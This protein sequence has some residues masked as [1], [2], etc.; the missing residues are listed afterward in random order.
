[1]KTGRRSHSRLEDHRRNKKRLQPPWLA[2]PKLEALDGA[3]DLLPELLWIDAL[4]R[5]SPERS[6]MDPSD[7]VMAVLGRLNSNA[8][9]RLGLISD[10]RLPRELHAQAL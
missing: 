6:T 3:R 2:I 5:V 9:P 1:R 8:P 7:A 10:L 4:Y